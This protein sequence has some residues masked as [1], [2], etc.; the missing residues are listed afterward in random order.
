MNQFRTCS[1]VVRLLFTYGV[2]LV[3]SWELMPDRDALLNIFGVL[4]NICRG[5]GGGG[6]CCSVLGNLE[7]KKLR[8]MLLCVGQCGPNLLHVC[9]L[10]L[11][12]RSSNRKHS[13]RHGGRSP[14]FPADG[15]QD[16]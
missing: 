4:P 13:G 11:L 3:P 5:V 16:A 14:T 6:C 2:L 7:D 8:F 9:F 1:L 10:A 15:Y 12:V